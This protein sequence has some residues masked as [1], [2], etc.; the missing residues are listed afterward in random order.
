MANERE[1]CAELV[2]KI[3]M[4]EMLLAGGEMTA[5]EKRTLKAFQSWIAHKIRSRK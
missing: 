3:T 4:Q 2:E 5:G 1:L